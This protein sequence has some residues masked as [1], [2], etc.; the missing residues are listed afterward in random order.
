MPHAKVHLS[1]VLKQPGPCFLHCGCH[2]W[3]WHS[4]QCRARSLA[5]VLVQVVIILLHLALQH[6]AGLSKVAWAAA[7]SGNGAAVFVYVGRSR[8]AWACPARAVGMWAGNGSH[9]SSIWRCV[10][11]SAV[12]LTWSLHL[13][14]GVSVDSGHHSVYPSLLLHGWV[15]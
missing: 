8:G 2:R 3:E 10:R 9:G 12:F 7:I 11:V 13:V 1:L 15:I 6:G 14:S 4:L 5:Q